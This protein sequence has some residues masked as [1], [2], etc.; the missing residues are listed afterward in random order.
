MMFLKK[1][2]CPQGNFFENALDK[3]LILCYNISCD[4]KQ[5][6]VVELADTRDLKSLEVKFVPVQVRSAALMKE[7]LIFQ[8]FFFV[9]CVCW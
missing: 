7:T 9:L 2:L 6:A 8:R 5:A 4:A 3:Y 1:F